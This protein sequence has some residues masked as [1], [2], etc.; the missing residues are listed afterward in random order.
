MIR[1]S[2]TSLFAI[3]IAVLAVGCGDDDNGDDNQGTAQG[4]GA[5]QISGD[6][7]GEKSGRAH[8]DDDYPADGLWRISISDETEWELT[9]TWDQGRPETGSYTLGNYSSVASGD[10]GPAFQHI[11][12]SPDVYG[13]E[14]ANLSETFGTLEI[15]ESSED[16]V[17]GTFSATLYRSNMEGEAVGG[18]VA[19]SEGEF[20]AHRRSSE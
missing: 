18:Q 10:F 1:I 8:F 11:D 5:L 6:Y 12:I 14:P 15:T 13:P 16:V 19:I 4:E 20:T 7:E 9:F 17:A 3:A 2:I